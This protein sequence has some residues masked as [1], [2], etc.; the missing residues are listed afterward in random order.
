MEST[1]RFGR[2]WAAQ[3]EALALLVPSVIVPIEFNVLLNPTH[4]AFTD[5][6]WSGPTPF[7]FD[8]RLIRSAGAR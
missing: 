3:P 7:R 8:G 1:R 6:V 2:R 4:S 5:L